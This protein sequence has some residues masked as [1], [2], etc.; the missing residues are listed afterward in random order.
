M[1]KLLMVA[2]ALIVVTSSIYA[3]KYDRM[4]K[5]AAKKDAKAGWMVAPGAMPLE[6]QYARSFRMQAELNDE[7]EPRWIIGEAMSI[8][9]NYDG[10]KMQALELSIQQ[11]AEKIQSTVAAEIKNS[12]ANQQ[13]KSEDAATV[14]KSVLSGKQWITNTI[15]KVVTITECYQI[16]SNKNRNVRVVTAYDEKKAI[17]GTKKELRKKLEEEGEELSEELDRFLGL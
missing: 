14:M 12:E 15:G 11:I 13:L 1:K 9:E 7:G 6:D 8:G 3:D 2:M 17:D 4:G 16:L 10:A 5:K